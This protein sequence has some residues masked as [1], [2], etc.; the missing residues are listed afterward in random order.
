LE[1][2]LFISLEVLKLFLPR[3]AKVEYANTFRVV[4]AL[5][6]LGMSKASQGILIS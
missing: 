2:L 5:Q 3:I 4:W 1:K 6:N